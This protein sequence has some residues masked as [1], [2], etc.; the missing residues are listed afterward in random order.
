M[1]KQQHN[2]E[3]SVLLAYGCP[4]NWDDME[5]DD[6]TRF[7]DRCAQNVYNISAMSEKEAQEIL[8]KNDAGERQCV[9]YFKRHDG[10]IVFD[11]CPVFLRPARDRLRWLR[12]SVSIL[13]SIFLSA[14][15]SPRA[16]SA[17]PEQIANEPSSISSKGSIKEIRHLDSIDYGEFLGWPASSEIREQ[18]QK[19]WKST[20]PG[21]KASDTFHADDEMLERFSKQTQETGNVDLK[22]LDK[23]KNFYVENRQFELAFH[24]TAAEWLIRLKLD[25]VN[26]NDAHVQQCLTEVEELRQKAINQILDRLEQD[27]SSQIYSF[28]ECAG[29]ALGLQKETRSLPSSVRIWNIGRLVSTTEESIKRLTAVLANRKEPGW[30]FTTARVKYQLQNKVNPI[31]VECTPESL[32]ADRVPF[33]SFKIP[34]DWHQT[35]R[36]ATW[37]SGK[38]SYH[39]AFEPNSN[40]EGVRLTIDWNGKSL[41]SERFGTPPEWTSMMTKPPHDLDAFELSFLRTVLKLENVDSNRF[42]LITARTTSWNGKTVIET[43]GE[44]LP[45]KTPALRS[46]AVTFDIQLPVTAATI[47]YSA[48]KNEFTKFKEAAIDAMRAVEWS[49][50]PGSR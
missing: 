13:C 8:R 24:A 43:E 10:T 3:P 20:Y 31:T 11:N 28:H 40:K 46:Y 23:L 45:H 1:G 34:T 19:L 27:S 25:D 17:S 6:S 29:D 2:R 21:Y 32:V 39:Y 33:E 22:E 49:R 50:S 14:V 18:L 7:C 41:R 37:P 12:K 35:E 36:I 44:T 4:V 16:F 5:G 42:K 9:R 38:E 26:I 15:S 48:P 47:C 30:K